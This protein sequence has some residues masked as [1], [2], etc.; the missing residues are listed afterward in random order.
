MRNSGFKREGQR[1]IMCFEDIILALDAYSY[2]LY[3]VLRLEVDFSKEI[4]VKKASVKYLA[5]KSG[6]SARKVGMSLNILEDFGLI[7]RES[8]L[9]EENTYLVSQHLY[10]FS[11]NEDEGGAHNMQGG[12]HNMQGGAHNMR[13]YNHYSFNNNINNTSYSPPEEDVVADVKKTK[14]KEDNN[15]LMKELIEIY[16]HELREHE[17]TKH[18]THPLRPDVVKTLNKTIKEWNKN[19]QNKFTKELFT[20]YLRG[21]VN[22]NHWLLHPY[23]TKGGKR[24]TKGIPVIC[25][26]DSILRALEDASNSGHRSDQ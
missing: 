6:M 23:E 25:R 26:W 22:V 4:G 7:I 18:S 10:Y 21:L 17:V 9:G 5:E 24:V 14:K 2:K 15:E 11:N 8:V 16:N 19:F 13:T 1:Y 12:A 20:T 3:S